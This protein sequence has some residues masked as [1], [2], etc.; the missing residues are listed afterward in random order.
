M[1]QCDITKALSDYD[2]KVQHVGETLPDEQRVFRVEV[3]EACMK[4]G[5]PINKLKHFRLLLEKHSF[6]L[7]DYCG[8]RQGF[9]QGGAGGSICPP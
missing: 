9:F 8:M 7:P 5:I 1:W 6:K 3:I 4:A 2:T